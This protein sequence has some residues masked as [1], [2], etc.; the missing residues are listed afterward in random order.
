MEK[1]KDELIRFLKDNHA[2]NE[3]K[4]E[5]KKA[6]KGATLDSVMHG[7]KSS[8]SFDVALKDGVALDYNSEITDIDWEELNSKW[9]ELLKMEEVC[10]GC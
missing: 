10:D 5:L 1:M 4:I 2:F 7:L 6:T 8:K 9:T 3:F